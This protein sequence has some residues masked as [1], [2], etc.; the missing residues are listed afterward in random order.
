M[1][2]LPGKYIALVQQKRT[3]DFWCRRREK[4]EEHIKKNDN[5][6]P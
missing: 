5:I 2:S 1:W 4:A 6:R 3:L